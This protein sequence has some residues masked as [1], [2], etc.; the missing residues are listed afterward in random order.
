MLDK[1]PGFD[2]KANNENNMAR[3]LVPTNRVIHVQYQ[4]RPDQRMTGRYVNAYEVAH[5]RQTTTAPWLTYNIDL[6]FFTLHQLLSIRLIYIHMQFRRRPD[7]WNGLLRIS[8]RH[9]EAMLTVASTADACLDVTRQ[10]HGTS[11]SPRRH[12]THN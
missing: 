8:T 7:G 1:Y 2:N 4:N 10:Y 9:A 12:K 6:I 11:G 5:D 3:Q